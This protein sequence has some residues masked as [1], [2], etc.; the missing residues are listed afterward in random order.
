M[1][2]KQGLPPGIA[3]NPDP[4]FSQAAANIR[5]EEKAAAA[6][7][8][9]EKQGEKDVTSVWH[10]ETHEE[11]AVS[12]KIC[13]KETQDEQAEHEKR[14]GKSKRKAT[15]VVYGMTRV[16]ED[17]K[18]QVVGTITLKDEAGNLFSVY[19]DGN[20]NLFDVENGGR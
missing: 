11:K 14:K 3:H 6:K 5:R 4:T 12:A 16:A 2:K 20:G 9:Q 19:K 13:E 17:A 8:Q 7:A 18:Y 10:A 15:R 1:I